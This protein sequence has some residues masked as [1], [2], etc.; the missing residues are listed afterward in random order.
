MS[1][2]R[3]TYEELLALARAGR[4]IGGRIDDVLQDLGKAGASQVDGIKVLVEIEGIGLGEAKKVVD[5]SPVWA[6]RREA[7]RR[8]R[9]AA[10]RTAR[11]MAHS[12]SLLSHEASSDIRER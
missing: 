7:N 3:H 11:Q 5:A 10:L 4:P 8:A 12:M 9:A 1:T 2:D 6:D